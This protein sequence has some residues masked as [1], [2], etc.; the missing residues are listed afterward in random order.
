M[1]AVA[2]SRPLEV[3]IADAEAQLSQAR[4]SYDVCGIA[5]V[6]HAL[7]KLASRNGDA[8]SP[9]S[10]NTLLRLRTASLALL[11]RLQTKPRAL[12]TTT[13]L[14][15][16]HGVLRSRLSEDA[17]D[18]REVAAL[19]EA[20]AALADDDP[21]VYQRAVATQQVRSWVGWGGV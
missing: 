11:C 19:Q 20:Q 4:A 16:L 21:T 17:L 12:E 5:A 2:A 9:A 1:A 15:E 10:A 7:G 13:A 3:R 18:L 14:A 8:L 6:A